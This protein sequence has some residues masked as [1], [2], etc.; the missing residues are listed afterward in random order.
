MTKTEALKEKY[1]PTPWYIAGGYD[2]DG[3]RKEKICARQDSTI[4]CEMEVWRG[5]ARQESEANAAFI[6][7]AVNAHADLINALRWAKSFIT[8]CE[9]FHPEESER[10]IAMQ[11][12]IMIEDAIAKAEAAPQ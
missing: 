2:E 4:I 3:N 10:E 5:E 7:R 6:V 8:A 9:R 1:T 12:R 11:R